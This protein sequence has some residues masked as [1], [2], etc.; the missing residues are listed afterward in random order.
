[1]ENSF[2]YRFVESVFLFQLSAG[3]LSVGQQ[4]ADINADIVIFS[5]FLFF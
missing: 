2:I 5:H 3:L 4:F 1:M